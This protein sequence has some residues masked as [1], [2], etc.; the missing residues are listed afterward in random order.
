NYYIDL[1]SKK[2][3]IS[4]RSL[5]KDLAIEDRAEYHQSIEKTF[6]ANFPG[7][8]D[9]AEDDKGQ[10]VFLMNELGELT[11][12]H[13]KEVE[14]SVLTPPDKTHLP[15]L[16]PREAE[17]F[18]HYQAGDYASL[19]NDVLAYLKRFSYQEE[20]YW[21]ILALKVFLTYLQDHK[22]IQYIP[23]ILFYASPERGK[24]RTG[25][26][27]I[28]IS[29]R[30]VHVV[31]L[32]EANLF[33][34]SQDLKATLFLDLMNLW[35]KAQ[36]NGSEDVLLLRFEKGA[37]VARVLF[38]EKGAF[39]DTRYYSVYGPTI[40]A[41]NEALH[42]ILDTRCIPI[43]VP[44]K[45]GD[46]EN[47]SPDLGLEL[48]ERLTAWRAAVLDRALPQVDQIPGIQGRL[49]DISK[50]VLQVCT[51]VAPERYNDLVRVL[52]EVAGQRVEDRK[53]GMEGRM[54]AVLQTLS[55]SDVAEEWIV[56]TSDVLEELNKGQPEGYKKTGQW[57]GR[58]LKG[59]G[60]RTRHVN[61]RSEIILDRDGFDSLLAQYVIPVAVPDTLP[62]STTLS[63]SEIPTIHTGRELDDS[64]ESPPD[65]YPLQ[66]ADS[67]SSLSMVDSGRQFCNT[68]PDNSS[69]DWGFVPEGNE[70]SGVDYVTACA[71]R[72]VPTGNCRKSKMKVH[73]ATKAMEQFCT[74]NGKWCHVVTE[75]DAD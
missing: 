25:K 54:I 72:P 42:N 30:G 4:K 9:L 35:Q 29:Y 65:V 41:T 3:G 52:L 37:K 57:I 19:F 70:T 34:F 26:A 75:G 63:G 15:F 50:P 8:I 11:R 21:L 23:M 68:G 13:E 66:T 14:G 16:L 39:Q 48:K 51:L 47:P 46:Y 55:P 74:K 6:S 53:Q 17:V 27:M 12:Y 45:P 5:N 62:K 56:R 18:K 24:S 33:R 28:T 31:D 38:P 58:K 59:M 60:I 73:P 22:D 7:L 2:T 64:R 69:E 67:Q 36:R 1:L 10:A 32:R 43:T 44:N 61:G 49:W 20:G 71:D 40:I